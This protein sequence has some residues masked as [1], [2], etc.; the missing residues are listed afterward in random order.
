M[1]Y[2]DAT[3]KAAEQNF[4]NVVQN[5]GIPE[6]IETVNITA[7]ILLADFMV[8]N[9]LAESKGEAKRLISQG[10]VKINNEKI[11]D[12]AFVIQKDGQEKILQAGKR[13]FIKIG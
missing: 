3:A 11:S 5:K 12:L 1:Y 7:S 13:K 4:V 2:D 6:N 10:A 8:S 9:G